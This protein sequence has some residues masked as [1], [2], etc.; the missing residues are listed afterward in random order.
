M[1]ATSLFGPYPVI[2]DVL[3]LARAIVN[4]TFSGAT[5]TPG[6]GRT[7]TDNAPFTLP[8]LNS[9]IRRLTQQLENNNVT[10]FTVDN[11]VL[12]VPAVPTPDA[13]VQVNISYSGYFD[14]TSQNANPS[15]PPDMLV[16]L[17]IWERPTGSA[18]EFQR[19]DQVGVL[20]SVIQGNYL[21]FWSWSQDQ[22][23]FIGAVQSTDIRIRYKSR[24]LAPISSSTNFTNTVIPCA[25]CADPLAYALARKYAVARNGV[26]PPDL[27]EEEQDAINQMVNRYVRAQQTTSFS[28]IPY[29]AEGTR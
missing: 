7:L 10:T 12:T 20:P 15:L 14:G 27:K 2:E 16:P 6:E 19:M 1:P 11:F 24:I 3:N 9:A 28:R 4:D 8:L 29:G 22:L 21:K 5:G 25:D 26:C 23:N 17:E 13:G 18:I